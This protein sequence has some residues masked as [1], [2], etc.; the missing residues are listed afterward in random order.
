MALAAQAIWAA[1]SAAQI[2]ILRQLDG[3]MLIGLILGRFNQTM[4]R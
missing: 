4:R 2:A 3:A 1:G